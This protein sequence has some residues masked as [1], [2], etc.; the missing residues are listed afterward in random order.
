[1]SSRSTY[2]VHCAEEIF[3]PSA[4]LYALEY[5]INLS[6]SNMLH[7]GSL[8]FFLIHSVLLSRTILRRFA[9]SHLDALSLMRCGA[10]FHLSPSWVSRFPPLLVFMDLIFSFF[11]LCLRSWASLHITVENHSSYQLHPPSNKHT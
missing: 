8:I 7:L 3:F 5:Y 6:C 9:V 10:L 2:Q 1:M 11:A 4:T